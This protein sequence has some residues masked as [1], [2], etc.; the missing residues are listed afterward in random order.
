MKHR[1]SLVREGVA[2]RLFAGLLLAVW[3]AA[4]ITRTL[5]LAAPSA[6]PLG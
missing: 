5:S 6:S 1:R 2:Q 4:R 3:V